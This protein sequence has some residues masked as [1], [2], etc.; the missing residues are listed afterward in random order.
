[1]LK[2]SSWLIR[3]TLHNR[4]S[5]TDSSLSIIMMIES[6]KESTPL[7][8]PGD[9]GSSYEGRSTGEAETDPTKEPSLLSPRHHGR[10]VV[11]LAASLCVAAVILV[12]ALDSRSHPNY[13][14]MRSSTSV[15]LPEP[16]L[17]ASLPA[18]DSSLDILNN[19]TNSTIV[20]DNQTF[21]F[22]LNDNEPKIQARCEWVVDQ[23]LKRDNNSDPE[24]TRERYNKQSTDFNDFYRAT[25]HIFWSD[26]VQGHWGTGLTKSL[27]P[28]A[29]LLDDVPVD[30]QST[31]CWV[32]GD[33][34][35]SN[36]GAWRNR[37]G[38]VVFGVNDFD[39][40]AIYDFQVDVLRIAVSVYNH[41]LTN[42]LKPE[43][44]ERV[45]QKFTDTYVETVLSY[46]GNEDALLFELTSKTTKGFL[47]QF[48]KSVKSG[49]SYEKQMSKFTKFE[50]GLRSFQ[51]G[52]TGE[53]DPDTKL[54]ALTPEREAQIRSAFTATRYGATMMKLGW[55]VRHW[56]D[57]FFTVLDVAARVGSG[58]GSY[59]VDRY[60]VLLKGTDTL[61]DPVST[62]EGR[63][64]VVL[65]VKYEP[66][67]AVSQVL[68][69]QE[70]A[71]YKVLFPNEAARTIE[72][73]RRLTSYTDPF[74]GWVLLPDQ[75]GV[76]QPFAVRQRSPWKD[77]PNLDKLTDPEE[78]ADFIGQIAM[79]TAT[80][81]VRGSVSK[82]PGAFKD[83]IKA[84]L[85]KKSKRRTWG[86]AVSLLASSYHKQVLLDYEC[87]ANYVKE[88]Y[89][90]SGD[91]E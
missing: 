27:R 38:D 33:Q 76:E 17:G 56:D 42:E 87:F 62:E 48:L 29:H 32:T 7:I 69:P 74:T 61:L 57:N 15:E 9:G 47:K 83:V 63:A 3:A 4:F 34:H 81:H 35:L 90:Q 54:E 13:H 73:Q 70:Q 89:P 28:D 51:K 24:Q 14:P 53:P 41:A 21:A 19:E 23:F 39:E 66:A 16:V 46:L 5:E 68:T 8:G 36:F 43:D 77:A 20:T 71:W 6:S 59:G 22:P 91:S 37:H 78:Y 60:Y 49:G 40:A 10:S 30:P 2:K 79:A 44:V 65:D 85:G 26:F 1:M 31:Y 64:G 72:A 50:D 45:M 82:K 75:N 80:S 52:P 88:N 11:T 12:I 18:G 58:I 55:A 86:K 25:A 84:L 67:G